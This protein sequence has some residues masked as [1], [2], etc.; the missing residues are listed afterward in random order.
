MPGLEDQS[1]IQANY[2]PNTQSVR[3]FTSG[4]RKYD[5]N[6]R[7]PDIQGQNIKVDQI[8]YLNG[9]VR[10]RISNQMS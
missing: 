4:P 1:E 5:I 3:V 7:I 8:K 2:E 10:I 9:I 6:V